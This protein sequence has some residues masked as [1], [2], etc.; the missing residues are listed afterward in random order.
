MGVNL[1]ASGER[2]APPGVNFALALF[3]LENAS[4]PDLPDAM[5]TLAELLA[6]EGEVELAGSKV[7][8][9]GSGS[10]CSA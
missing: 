10:C 2:Q 3:A 8:L 6:A 5:G 1:H 9:K 7:G 4:A